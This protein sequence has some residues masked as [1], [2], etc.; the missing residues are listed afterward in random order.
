MPPTS[1]RARVRRPDRAATTDEHL[2]R[3]VVTSV[4]RLEP[5]PILAVAVRRDLRTNAVD[6]PISRQQDLGAGRPHGGVGEGLEHGGEKARGGHGV[7]VDQYHQGGC[8][9]PEGDGHPTG[10][11]GVRRDRDHLDLRVPVGQQTQGVI[12]RS[13]VDNDDLYRAGHTALPE[14]RI[15]A[16]G[17]PVGP[18]VADHDDSDGGGDD[19]KQL[20]C[21]GS[22]P[23]RRQ[24]CE[25]WHGQGSPRDP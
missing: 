12:A 8:L 1:L 25:R 13:V 20:T 4:V 6:T 23:I 9:V 5:A 10:K 7:V 24:P 17:Q 21:T 15:Q 14:Q 3:G 11:A 22:G 2:C 19:P 16:A 18:V